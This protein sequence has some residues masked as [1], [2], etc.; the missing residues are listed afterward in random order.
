MKNLLLLLII[1]LFISCSSDDRGFEDVSTTLIGQGNIG[2]NNTGFLQ[3]QT[4]VIES[5]S[6]WTSFLD[7]F[8]GVESGLLSNTSVDFDF[9][10]VV[11]VID[12]SRENGDHVINLN[13]RSNGSVI[14]ISFESLPQDD[15]SITG[16]TQPYYII[17]VEN[18]DG[19]GVE[20]EEL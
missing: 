1:T 15:E 5:Q 16:S 17:S 9:E 19:L 3:K 6:Q 13:A 10:T 14:R 2:L 18:S 11:V 20:F 12:E 8:N 7:T 4:T